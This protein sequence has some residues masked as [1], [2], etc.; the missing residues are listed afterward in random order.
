MLR[1][2]VLLQIFHGNRSIEL[3]QNLGGVARWDRRPKR[4]RGPSRGQ[5]AIAWSQM[6]VEVT[7]GF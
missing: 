4:D 3:V 1:F 6:A 2:A 5:W 7:K